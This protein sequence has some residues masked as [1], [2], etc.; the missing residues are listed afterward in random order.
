MPLLAVALLL[1][2]GRTA[3]VGARPRNRPWTTAFLLAF[4]FHAKGTLGL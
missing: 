1:L 2:N 3:W 4:A